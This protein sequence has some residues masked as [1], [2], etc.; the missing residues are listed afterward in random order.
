MKK[1]AIL[2]VMA[3]AATT[4]FG[5]VS[6]NWSNYGF[7][8]GADANT[9]ATQDGVKLVWDLVYTTASAVTTP[10]LDTKTGEIK[11]ASTDEVLSRR[12]WDKNDEANKNN[13][14][15]TDLVTSSTASSTPLVADLTYAS[16]KTGSSM[17]KNFDDETRTSGG[18]YAA[19]FQ[20]MADGQVYGA[21]TEVNTGINFYNTKSGKADTVHFGGASK[22][23]QIA[24]DMGKVTQVPEPATMSLLGLGALAMVIRRKLR[25]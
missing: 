22:D 9:Y 15:V 14:V 11:Y 2:A 18:I 4:S 20:Y 23:V 1:T 21:W 19:V 8:S 25:K 7:T 16:I 24:T 6:I 13:W 3:V 12:I 10:T 17:Y 5:T